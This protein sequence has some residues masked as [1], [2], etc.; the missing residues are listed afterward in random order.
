MK[1][2]RS[3]N[4]SNL[5]NRILAD[6]SLPS[7]IQKLDGQALAKMIQEIGLEDA[8][9]L[10]ALASVKQLE[11]AFDHD[12]WSAIRPGSD[13]YFDPER[14]AT[15]IEILLESGST[16][17]ALKISEMDEELVTMAFSQ[18]LWA[19]DFETLKTEVA[20]QDRLEKIMDSSAFLEIEDY[21][22][23][24]KLPRTWDSISRLLVDLDQNHYEFLRRVLDNCA[25]ATLDQIKDQGDFY[26]VLSKAD[27][28]VQDA[29]EA[30]EKRREALG[31]VSPANARAFLKLAQGP[32]A[33][34]DHLTPKE[35]RGLVVNTHSTLPVPS[36]K[37][38]R[39]KA[40][41]ASDL[42]LKSKLIEQLNYLANVL[43]AGGHIEGR[44]PRPGEASVWVLETCENGLKL[45]PDC[46]NLIEAFRAGWRKS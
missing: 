17:A 11:E 8:G 30:R 28:L 10:V 27:Q 20:S 29:S 19:I 34:E 46:K 5:L 25:Q 40:F 41:I 6:A 33:S 23:F 26:T 24:S 44:A 13:E 12:L 7:K 36:A 32:I 4:T 38:G 31:Y 15:W 22:I 9:E 14:F 39:V 16:V 18:L 3:S 43:V 2:L 1:P 42:L 37:F 21:F 35:L 45:R